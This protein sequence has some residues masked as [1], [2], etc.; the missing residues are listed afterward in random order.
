MADAEGA[1][2]LTDKDDEYYRHNYLARKSRDEAEQRRYKF[3]QRIA[4][5]R[6]ELAMARVRYAFQ[7][8]FGVKDNSG[9]D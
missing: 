7:I 3:F 2:Q 8:V 1:E 9:D 6:Y 4:D 5:N